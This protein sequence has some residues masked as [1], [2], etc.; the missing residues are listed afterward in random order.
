VHMVRH[1]VRISLLS[2]D[3]ACSIVYSVCGTLRQQLL[4]RDEHKKRIQRPYLPMK[5]RVFRIVIVTSFEVA[6]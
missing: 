5:P 2:W 3:V 4:G 6:A 1:C